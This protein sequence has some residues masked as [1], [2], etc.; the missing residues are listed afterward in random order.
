MRTKVRDLKSLHYETEYGDRNYC[1][2]YWVIQEANGHTSTGTCKICGTT[3][4]FFN[5]MP[6]WSPFGEMA[7]TRDHDSVAQRDA[8]ERN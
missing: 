4:E 2:H 1:P 3:R 7:K 5:S 6:E 8:N